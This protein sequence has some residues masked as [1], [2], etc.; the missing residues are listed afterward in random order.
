MSLDGVQITKLGT[1]Q[2]CPVV[3]FNLNLPPTERYKMDNILTSMIIPGPSEPHNI[4]SFLYPLVEEMK[5]LGSEG[6][7]TFDGDI[8]TWFTLRS[9]ITIVQGKLTTIYLYTC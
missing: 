6:V 5:L 7:Q 2:V 4:D 1:F 9:W 3:L 8:Q